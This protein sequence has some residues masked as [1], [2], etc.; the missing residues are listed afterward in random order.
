MDGFFFFVVE[1][2][3]DNFFY[4]LKQ[5][6]QGKG[7][8]AQ[9][10]HSTECCSWK[11]SK[12]IY[13]KTWETTTSLEHLLEF[14]SFKGEASILDNCTFN[15]LFDRQIS[16]L[17]IEEFYNKFGIYSTLRNYLLVNVIFYDWIGLFHPKNV[18][19]K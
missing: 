11:T 2:G 13:S 8:C 1:L 15:N 3:F 18:T 4:A 17:K 14:D 9:P 12:S 16:A 6:A 19:H 10:S 5:L 7:V